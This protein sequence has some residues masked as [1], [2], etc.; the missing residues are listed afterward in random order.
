MITGRRPQWSVEIVARESIGGIN[1][2]ERCRWAIA[3]SRAPV[4]ASAAPRCQWVA[5]ESGARRSASRNS[6]MASSIALS[7]R[8]SVPAGYE[9]PQIPERSLRGTRCLRWSGLRVAR[10]RA[11]AT[12]RSEAVYARL[13]S[14]R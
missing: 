5:A 12:S 7:T 4:S 13:R 11:L 9:G 10:A 8:A 3:S 1:G 6:R 14:A 2:D